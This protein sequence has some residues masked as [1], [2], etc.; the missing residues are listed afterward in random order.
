MKSIPFIILVLNLFFTGCNDNDS[1]QTNKYI[2]KRSGLQSTKNLPVSADTL[3]QGDIFIT[4]GPAGAMDQMQGKIVIISDSGETM[5]IILKNNKIMA[6]DLTGDRMY[7][8]KKDSDKVS[9]ML[10]DSNNVLG[11][12]RM[13]MF[14]DDGNLLDVK[15]PGNNLVVLT[16][17]NIMLPL[18][19]K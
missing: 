12:G 6:V 8:V 7:A 1:Y 14:T 13:M 4:S 15:L 3:R 16:K 11:Y 18:I 19:K 17:N 9:Y 2:N 10:P 5:P